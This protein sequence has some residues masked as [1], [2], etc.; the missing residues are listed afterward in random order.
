MKKIVYTVLLGKNKL[1]LNE[2]KCRNDDWELVCFTDRDIK[3]RNWNIKKVTCSNILKKSR[4]IKIRCDKYLDFDVCIYLDSQFIIKCNLNR[5]VKDN[6]KNNLALM[7]H[8]LR[9]CIYREARHCIRKHKGDRNKIKK[10]IEKYSNEGFPRKFG[11]YACGIM[12]RKNNS[13]VVDFMKLW[14]DEVE[15]FSH[16]DQISFPYV[17]WKNP[18]K[19]DVLNFNRTR[20][21]F[22]DL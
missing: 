14:Y 20:S 16:R 8:S 6:L 17:L 4:E 13:E 11:L 5:F 3:S 22:K 7:R 15:K 1:V 18:I 12:I 9:N 2:P 10:Q 21:Q 19:F